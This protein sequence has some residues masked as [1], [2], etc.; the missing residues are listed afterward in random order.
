MYLIDII[1]II[2]LIDLIDLQCGSTR[3]DDESRRTSEP[4]TMAAEM[5]TEELIMRTDPAEFHECQFWDRFY[6][7]RGG[8]AFEWYGSWADIA[9]LVDAVVGDRAAPLLV[10]GCGNSTLSEDMHEGG[11]F[12][13][14]NSLDYSE[15]VIAEMSRYIRIRTIRCFQGSVGGLYGT[16]LFDLCRGP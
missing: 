14:V 5:S 7:T 16:V 8:E 10:L 6:A 3:A 11:G 2:D 15:A 12:G 13:S 9:P 4:R 1:D